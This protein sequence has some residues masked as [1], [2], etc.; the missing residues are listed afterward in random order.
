MPNHVAEAP[1]SS[2]EAADR[3][4]LHEVKV[5]RQFVKF[6]IVGGTS[7]VIDVGLHYVLMFGIL[8]GGR[9]LGETFGEWLLQ[10]F[11]SLFAFAKDAPA[12]AVPVFK[13][14]TAGLAIVNSFIWNRRWT[15]RIVGP[16]ERGRQF[17]RFLIVSLIGMALNTLVLTALNN[18]IPGHAKR[19]WAVASAVATVVVAFWNFSGQK[20]WAFRKKA[21]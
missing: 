5:L 7:N 2:S 19:S 13:V 1:E 8:V 10:A 20:L 12:A 14:L 11:P 16:E 4:R 9:P 21:N 15:F 17:H 6:A 3:R 18:V